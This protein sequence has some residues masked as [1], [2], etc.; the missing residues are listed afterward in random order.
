MLDQI[1]VRPSLIGAVEDLDILDHD[2]TDSLLT[3]D[4]TPSK[5]YL[6]DH[7]PITFRVNI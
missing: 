4:R 5:D 3:D 6:S 1:L 7:L 2:G